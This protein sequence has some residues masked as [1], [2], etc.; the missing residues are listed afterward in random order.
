MQFFLLI[1]LYFFF[2][3]YG[4]SC[5]GSKLQHLDLTGCINI[6]DVTLFSLADAN[7][8]FGTLDYSDEENDNQEEMETEIE[9]LPPS[10]GS[11]IATCCGKKLGSDLSF[12]G[13]VPEET[14]FS[15]CC[16]SRQDEAKGLKVTVPLMDDSGVYFSVCDQGSGCSCNSQTA[17]PS[18]PKENQT[19]T[20]SNHS[21]LNFFH[22]GNPKCDEEHKDFDFDNLSSPCDLP[23]KDV[24]SL[25]R[26][27][28]SQC[29]E[30]L[31]ETNSA[32]GTN[33]CN[34]ADNQCCLTASNISP[35]DSHEQISSSQLRFLSLNGCYGISDQGLW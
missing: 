18:S 13:K 14:D 6:T 20:T 17:A 15:S 27:L 8:T 11:K 9:V 35:A 32:S 22:F 12:D 21:P 33:C 10:C 25:Q 5:R 29:C 16:N 23:G 26:D 24:N 28:D 3:R 31:T 30:S 4:A 19:L 1:V 34:T 2:V 7:C